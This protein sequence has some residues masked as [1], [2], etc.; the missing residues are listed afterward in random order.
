MVEGFGQH[1]VRTAGFQPRYS[2]PI[3]QPFGSFWGARLD[4]DHVE[5][6]DDEYIHFSPLLSSPIWHIAISFSPETARVASQSPSP[7]NLAYMSRPV[8]VAALPCCEEIVGGFG[9]M[10]VLV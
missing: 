9:W 2:S 5:L 7:D 6:P 4:Y 10:S 8:P 1:S 3:L